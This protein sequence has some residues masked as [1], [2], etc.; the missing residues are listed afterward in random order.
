MRTSKLDDRQEQI[1]HHSTTCIAPHL[2]AVPDALEWFAQFNR[3]PVSARLWQQAK[4]A[5]MESLTNAIRHAHQDLPVTTPIDLEVTISDC[6]LQILIWDQGKTFD[7]EEL[8]ARLTYRN[9]TPQ[10]REAQWGIVLLQ[11]LRDKHQWTIC[12]RSPF[13]TGGDRNC[14]EISHP[15][16]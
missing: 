15:I 3:L 11:K 8:F 7:L 12:Y 6:Q 2:S 5:L 14:M 4:L 16:P 10:E 13:H 9:A 1:I